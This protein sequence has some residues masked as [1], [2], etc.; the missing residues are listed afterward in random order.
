MDRL[1]CAALSLDFHHAFLVGSPTK[2][3]SRNLRSTVPYIAFMQG[4]VWILLHEQGLS[5]SLVCLWPTAI[6]FLDGRRNS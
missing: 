3:E 2:F 4:K 6:N 5:V 1:L